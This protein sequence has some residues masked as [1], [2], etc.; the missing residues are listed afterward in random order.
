[1]RGV[2]LEPFL[3]KIKDLPRPRI[4]VDHFC[5]SVER[6]FL[7]LYCESLRLPNQRAEGIGLDV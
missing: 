7:L 4:L 1:M 3:I 6:P 5:K 2:A